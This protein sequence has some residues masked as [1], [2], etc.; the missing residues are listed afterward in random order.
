MRRCVRRWGHHTKPHLDSKIDLLDEPDVVARKIRKAVCG[1]N[2]VE[3]NGVLAFVE[4]VLLPVAALNGRDF[5]VDRTRDGLEPLVY[6]STA[7]L[8]EDY[9]NGVVCNSANYRDARS[10]L[11]P[12]R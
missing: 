4:Y 9:R 12:A 5:R 8:H 3:G 10:P 2:I 6:T 1:S 7:A 11:T